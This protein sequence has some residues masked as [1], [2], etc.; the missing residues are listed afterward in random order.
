MLLGAHVSIAGGVD[1]AVDR[2]ADFEMNAMQIFSHN[3]RSWSTRELTGEEIDKFQEKRKE[4][5]IEYAVA[6]TSYLLNLASPKDDLW[7]KSKKGLVEEIRRADLLGIQAVNT[8][9]G[10]HTGSGMES[11]I[12]RLVA[13]LKEIESTDVFQNSEVNILLE[14]TAGGGTK[15]GSD[16]SEL[17][18]VLDALNYS[19][20]YGVCIDTCH[21][22]AA[23][24]DFATE[25]GLEETLEEFDHEVGLDELKLIHLNDSVGD[26]GSRKDRHAHIG[27]GKIG[28]EGFVAV[29]N[30]PNLRELP[31]IL[32][33]PKEKL[34]GK[35]A[36]RVNL[37]K[38]MNMRE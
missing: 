36:D 21:G 37:D 3:V 29:V 23:G 12:N 24:Y 19:N 11:G 22:F 17:G 13:A 2:A 16:F 28:D 35:E 15:L 38:V 33:T 1:N 5:G 6:H 31:F 30:N 18:D 8:H 7:K 34:D 10:A 27:R 26:L 32:E 20:R 14:N 25:T 9:I 4:F